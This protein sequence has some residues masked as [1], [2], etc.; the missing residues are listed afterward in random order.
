MRKQVI[1]LFLCI[2]SITVYAQ[3]ETAFFAG[4]QMSSVKYTIQNKKQDNDYKYGFQAGATVKVPFEN[5]LYFAPS[6]FYSLKGYKVTLNKV[7]FPPDSLATDNDTRIHT[8]ELAAL[9]QYDFNQ[10]PGHFFVK[11]GP[12]LDIQLRGHEKF[13]RSNQTT[14]EQDMVF[15]FTEYGR[16]AANFI[17]QFGFES[18]AGLIV[19]AHYEHGIGSMNNADFG[20][21][22]WH[23]VYG[24]SI[25]KYLKKKKRGTG[26]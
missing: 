16:F 8:F 2:T 6:A 24:I 11:F 17:L 7:S 21:G 26:Q 14:I 23:R 5:K 13:N 22:I 15:S 10:H 1:T 3:V 19:F 20:P 18:K 25:G 12:S 4:P 9:L